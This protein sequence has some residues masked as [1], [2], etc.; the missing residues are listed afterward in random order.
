MS[1]MIKMQFPHYC[2]CNGVDLVPL[3]LREFDWDFKEN[4]QQHHPTMTTNCSDFYED[5]LHP[6]YICDGNMKKG[7]Y[8]NAACCCDT[9]YLGHP[10]SLDWDDKDNSIILECTA[11]SSKPERALNIFKN[12]S[13]PWE[14][15][16]LVPVSK[17]S[18]DSFKKG[19]ISIKIKA[20]EDYINKFGN[21]LSSAFI[22]KKNDKNGS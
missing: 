6:G 2:N 20:E 4:Y 10:A 16:S 14:Y 12:N 7:Y 15:L 22:A 21:W 19:M 3:F 5:G 9:C 1:D 11:E 13:T 17:D 18:F 8:E